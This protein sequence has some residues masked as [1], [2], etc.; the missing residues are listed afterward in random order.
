MLGLP[1]RIANSNSIF[2][3]F[4]LSSFIF[5]INLFEYTISGE[6]SSSQTDLYNA[7]D[8]LGLKGRINKFKIS[9]Q[10]IFGTSITRVSDKNSLKYFRTSFVE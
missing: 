1:Y 4:S 3:E 7:A 10:I 9:H 8:F 2:S 5:F 6:P